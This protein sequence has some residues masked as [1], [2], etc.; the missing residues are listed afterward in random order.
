MSQIAIMSFPF[1]KGLDV[2]LSPESLKTTILASILSVWVLIGLFTYLNRYTKRRYFTIWTVAWMFY[3]VWLSLHY[4]L[5]KYPEHPLMQ[6]A[7]QCCMGVAATFLLWGSFRFLGLK[8]RQMMLS[9]FMGFLVVWSY[10]A[11]FHFEKALYIQL[12]I[13]GL[14]GLASVLTGV[15]F[16]QYRRKKPFI[17]ATLLAF[18]FFLWGGFFA[19]YPFFEQTEELQTCGF[20]I[21]AVLQLFIAVSMIILVL[22][23]VRFANQFVFNQLRTHKTEK[24]L[25]KTRVISA[26]ERYRDLFDQAGEAIVIASGEDYRIL[27]LNAAAQRMF[28]VNRKEASHHRLNSFCHASYSQCIAP[29]GGVEWFNWACSQPHLKVIRKNGE[30]T[31]VELSGTPIEFENR[32][33][34]QF[35]FREMTDRAKLEQQ[36]RQSEK[37][38]ALGQMISGV[39]HELNNPL[40]VIKGYLEL[41]IAH[42]ELAPQTRTDLEK[43]AQ[44]C[45]RA[46]KL[47]RNFLAFARE[48]PAH[49]ESIVLNDIVRR[50]ADLR[51]FD[52]TKGNVE[53]SLELAANLP[54][55][56]AD[57]DQV[58]QIVNNLVTNAAQAM[59]KR[60][61]PRKL[62]V[63]T[64]ISGDT[65]RLT[66]EDNGPGVSAELES[67]IFEPFF[68]TKDPG[69]GTGLGLSI[70]HSIMTEHHGRIFCQPS[71]L[72]GAAFVL[73]FPLSKMAPRVEPTAPSV[74]KRGMRPIAAARILILDDEE[75]LADMLTEMLEMQ[76]HAATACLHPNRA[77]EL[78]DR[79]TFDLIISDFRMPGMNG[80]EFY[81]CV[82][83]KKPALAKRI[84]FLTGDIIADD[85][86]AFLESTGNPHLTKPFQLSAIEQLVADSLLK[87][88]SSPDSEK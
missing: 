42:H 70:A 61:K 46:A 16:F 79:E 9:L 43:V 18:G 34:Y 36:L 88:S 65:L 33:A 71:R 47:V 11:N 75:S 54:A 24:E 28:G 25:L 32:L 31:A 76:G 73:E 44:E 26:E 22:E 6:M 4:G 17:G 82:V 12:P 37:L 21:S 3:G 83:Q 64:Q 67:K 84:I 56:N 30:S 53:L 7:K 74:P 57:P 45:T 20:F 48:Q 63:S 13:F 66:V 81:R 52:L 72:G 1:L 86:H 5:L 68:T 8:V 39:A 51:K 62:K 78:I 2:Y 77:L 69:K 38:S 29:K 23:E 10:F 27:E 59:E 85:T 50:V 58:Q 41:V 60:E 19:G 40:A 49:R 15:S 87:F 80:Q 35:F 14:I 55:T